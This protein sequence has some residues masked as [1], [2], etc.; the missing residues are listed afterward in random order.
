M[1]LQTTMV[2]RTITTPAIDC[3]QHP[4]NQSNLCKKRH[5][6]ETIYIC[7]K[8]SNPKPPKNRKDK[9]RTHGQPKKTVSGH[10][11]FC[12]KGCFSEHNCGFEKS[13]R[14]RG[15]RNAAV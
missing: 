6:H 15:Y 3:Q 9:G 10:I 13:K 8:C 14:P 1:R 12:K 5:K 4:K 7:A 11:H 2:V